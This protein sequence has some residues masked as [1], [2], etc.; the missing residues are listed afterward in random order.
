MPTPRR[1]IAL[2]C[3]LI[4][5]A[6]ATVGCTNESHGDRTVTQPKQA[7]VHVPQDATTINAAL[8]KVADDGLVLIAGGTYPEQVLVKTPGV[9]LRGLDR[10]KVIITGEGK[11]TFGVVAIVDG[12]RVQNLTVTSTLLYGVLIT[13]THDGDEILT[14][15]SH[16]YDFDP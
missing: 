15:D 3:F 5:T 9:T 4:A 8:D 2:L 16:G 7:V 14:P 10:N 12:V 1:S 13:G 11:R 6:G